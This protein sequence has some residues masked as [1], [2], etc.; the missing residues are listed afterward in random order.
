MV[1]DLVSDRDKAETTFLLTL[2]YRYMPAIAPGAL[3]WQILE[4]LDLDTLLL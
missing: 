4:L 2:F 3:I 1:N